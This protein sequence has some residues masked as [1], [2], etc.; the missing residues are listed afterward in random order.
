MEL[1]V[2]PPRRWLQLRQSAAY[3]GW[4]IVLVSF[5]CIALVFA[6][7]TAAMP[8]IYGPVIDEFG[9]SRTEATLVFTYKNAASAVAALFLVGPLCERFGLRRVTVGAFV[10]TATAMLSFLWVSSIWTYYVAGIALGAGVS[11]T[12][13]TAKILVSRWFNR[14]QGLALG[15]MLAGT[16]VGGMMAPLAY[17]S[18]EST[19]GWRAAF[20]GLSLGIWAIALPLY[21]VKA[22]ENP[23][24]EDLRL[25][26]GFKPR[27]RAEPVPEHASAR[28][29]FVGM[30]AQPAFWLIVLSLLLVAAADAGLMQHTA[31]FLERDVGLTTGAAAAA[32]SGMFA[33]GIVAKIGAG[34]FYDKYSLKGISL[35]YILLAVSIA[36]AFSVTG[37]LTLIVFAAMRG[38]AHGG[39][40]LEPAVV[41][42][43]CYGPRLLHLTISIFIGVWAV[44]AALGA[45]LL[46]LLYDAQGTYR[47]GFLLLIVFSVIA[48]VILSRV[49]ATHHDRADSQLTERIA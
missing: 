38:I 20:A 22:D 34:C 46:S 36:L 15:M 47:I 41:A 27:R 9:W 30:I 3:K 4:G 39:L 26:P 13:V 10:T 44:G 40:M 42:K 2:L 24:A 6:S 31:L 21:L 19:L 5:V 37:A 45:I 28:A 48:A 43:H 8:L 18:I 23:T 32:L 35:W 12:F 1:F 49:R 14:N 25:E 33:L 11:A 29:H 7:S 17:A 16:S